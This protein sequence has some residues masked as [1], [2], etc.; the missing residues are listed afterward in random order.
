MENTDNIYVYKSTD[1]KQ[2]HNELSVTVY[3]DED[4]E[5]EKAVGFL[6]SHLV[7]MKNEWTVN[8]WS[9]VQEGD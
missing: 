5:L 8:M 7:E 1:P 9:T 4:V 3:F 6:S 2:L